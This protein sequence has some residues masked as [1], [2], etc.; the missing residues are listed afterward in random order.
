[1]LYINF[2]RKHLSVCY[3]LIV[4]TFYGIIVIINSTIQITISCLLLTS[5]CKKHFLAHLKLLK[6]LF[7]YRTTF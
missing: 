4:C 5:F 1:M 7:K 3:K 6:K 2:R